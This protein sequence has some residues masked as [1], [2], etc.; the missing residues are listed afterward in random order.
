MILVLVWTGCNIEPARRNE[1]IIPPDSHQI[2]E[3]VKQNPYAQRI[4]KSNGEALVLGA[5]TDADSDINRWNQY[6]PNYI[7]YSHLDKDLTNLRD[8]LNKIYDLKLGDIDWNTNAKWAEDLQKIFATVLGKPLKFKKILF[9]RIT[10][11]HYHPKTNLEDSTEAFKKDV[12][13]YLIAENGLLYIPKRISTNITTGVQKIEYGL[14]HNRMQN[15]PLKFEFT[16]S[17]NI[18]AALNFGN[19][20]QRFDVYR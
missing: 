6:E 14:D 12:R 3:E 19:P 8:S 1:P 7:G 15:E 10:V 2:P 4:I 20:A 5:Q 9:D 18:P 17:E 11:H 13:H 16:H